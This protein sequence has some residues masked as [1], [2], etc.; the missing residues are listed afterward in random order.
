M[1]I[2][3]PHAQIHPIY[4]II[5]KTEKY[6]TTQQMSCLSWRF[7]ELFAKKK[8]RSSWIV[9]TYVFSIR[10]EHFHI[11]GTVPSDTKAMFILDTGQRL[12]CI[13]C[14]C[15]AYVAGWVALPTTLCEFTPSAECTVMPFTTSCSVDVVLTENP[16]RK[17]ETS[18]DHAYKLQ[19]TTANCKC[20]SLAPLSNWFHCLKIEMISVSSNQ[21]GPKAVI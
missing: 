3:F 19:M 20:L 11:R 10:H 16:L 5:K 14:L 8:K 13:E 4:Y 6:D 12:Y 7:S 21:R 15:G 2:E 1:S 9:P 17:P 18:R